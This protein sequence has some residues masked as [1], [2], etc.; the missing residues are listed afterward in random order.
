MVKYKLYIFI[1]I[2]YNKFFFFLTKK[3][4]FKKVIGRQ[5]S[6][7]SREIG[8]CYT[9]GFGNGGKDHKP[10]NVDGF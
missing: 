3:L 8:R 9:S 10:R 1:F 4:L 5:D 6:Q 7:S 2:Y